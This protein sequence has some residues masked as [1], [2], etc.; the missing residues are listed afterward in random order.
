VLAKGKVLAAGSVDQMRSLVARKRISCVTSLDAA[1]L[2]TWPHV[3]NV[4][5]ENARTHIVATDADAVVRRLLAEDP[6]SRDLEVQ[7]AGLAEAF[8]ELT[9]EAA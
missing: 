8:A 1:L 7:R 5:Q 6:T 9:Q 3:T 2:R 4:S